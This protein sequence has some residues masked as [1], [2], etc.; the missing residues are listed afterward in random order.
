MQGRHESRE[1]VSNPLDSQMSI[2]NDLALLTSFSVGILEVMYTN[3]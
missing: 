2:K 1:M 3:L